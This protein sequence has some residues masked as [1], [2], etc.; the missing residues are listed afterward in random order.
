MVVGS[1]LLLL[2]GCIAWFTI[3]SDRKTTASDHL[4]EIAIQENTDLIYDATHLQPNRSRLFTYP[5]HPSER[6][7]LIVARDSK[8]T[9]RVAFAS[10]TA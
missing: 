6:K 2:F 1:L 10:C 8:R 9:M 5:V 4:P 3:W 7:R